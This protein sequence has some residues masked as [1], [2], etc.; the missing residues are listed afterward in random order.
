MSPALP[1]LWLVAMRIAE[2][3]DA[4]FIGTRSEEFRKVLNAAASLTAAIALFSYA[5]NLHLPRRYALITLPC[6]TL[7]DLVARYVIRQCL[8]RLRR[9]GQCVQSVMAIGHEWR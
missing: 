7:L 6:V 9:D 5:V 3:H 1:G 2:G 8:Y 4:R